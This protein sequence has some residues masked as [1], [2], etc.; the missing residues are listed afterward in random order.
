MQPA[1][2][3]TCIVRPSEGDE[4]VFIGVDT[5]GLMPSSSG[6]DFQQQGAVEEIAEAET[7]PE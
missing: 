2:N 1:W 3:N 7:T 6:H 5:G 4:V